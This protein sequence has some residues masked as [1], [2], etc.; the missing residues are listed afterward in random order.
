MMVF[1]CL[2]HWNEAFIKPLTPKYPFLQIP[3]P[4]LQIPVPFLRIPVPFL[5]TPADSSGMPPFLQESVGHGEVLKF[6]S[7][8]HL[9][10]T[11]AGDRL[12]SI[13]VSGL[14]LFLFLSLMN[15]SVVQW[16]SL[17]SPTDSR[18]TPPGL[19]DSTWTPGGLQME[20]TSI[21]NFV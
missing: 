3:V 15:Y 18:W 16:C 9:L 8:D 14:I 5:R 1:D 13:V 21:Y 11:T 17:P 4:F 20:K 7:S 12:P 6:T 19:H 10:F 2:F